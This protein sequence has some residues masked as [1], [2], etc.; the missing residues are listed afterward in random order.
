MFDRPTPAELSEAC[1]R[2]DAA[3]G[4]DPTPAQKYEARVA[5]NARALIQRQS[6]S[7][8]ETSELKRLR[9][10]LHKDGDLLTLNQALAAAIAARTISL[11]T[12]GLADHLWA[13]T[14]A[15]VA[16]DQPSYAA[17]RAETGA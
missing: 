13:T 14:L 16:V 17:F 11:A 9:N 10:L 3:L 12:P 5:A 7:L 6:A 4:P 15:K 1:D 2:F 8:E